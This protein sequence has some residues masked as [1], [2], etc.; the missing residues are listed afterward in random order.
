[1]LQRFCFS[2]LT[3][4]YKLPLGWGATRPNVNDV[5]SHRVWLSFFFAL[6]RWLIPRFTV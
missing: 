6:T 3:G 5:E 1:M 2:N 4:A